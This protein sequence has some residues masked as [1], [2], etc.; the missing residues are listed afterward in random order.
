LLAVAC[1]GPRISKQVAASAVEAAPLFKTP[2]VVY[3]PRLVAIPA[4][5]IG[6]S[7][8]TRQGEALTLNEIALVDPV[9]A[10]LRARD[11]VTV[12]DFVSAVP[13]SVVEPVKPDTAAKDSTKAPNDS[14][15]AH[16]DSTK[17]ESDST[18][19]A[20]PPPRQ[21]ETPPTSPPPQPPLAQQW[22]HTIRITPRPHLQTSDL[23]PDDGED[24]TDS[25]PVVYGGR[26]MNRTPGWTLAVGARELVRVLDVISYAPAHGEPPGEAQ[27]D[28]LWRWHSTRTGAPFDMESAEFQ[29]LPHELQQAAISGSVTIDGTTHWSR[30]TV[31]RNGASWKV[32]SVNWA[33]GDDKP[34]N[35]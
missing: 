27:I 33:Y 16:T 2:K 10:V 13:G 5:G 12:E 14:T 34:H 23:A 30:A 15:K 35:W 11:W 17:S 18:K 31:V 7:M 8:A 25:A 32:T 9:V 20:A 4:D 26:P 22:V 28:F 1:G 29:S 21:R 6:A 19:K 3:V 24:N